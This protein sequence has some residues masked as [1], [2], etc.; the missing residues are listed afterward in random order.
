MCKKRLSGLLSFVFWHFLSTA[1]R[2]ALDTW[3]G[4]S[5]G[6]C[7]RGRA[8]KEREPGPTLPF[9]V[10]PRTRY[11]L[12]PSSGLGQPAPLQGW[13]VHSLFTQCV[14]HYHSSCVPEHVGQHCSGSQAFE[15]EA[16]AS[17]DDREL[18]KGCRCMSQPSGVREGGY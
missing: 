4:T 12:F 2:E 18:N 5:C 11:F 14:N 7:P 6:P 3:G 16:P 9:A 8:G 13:S 17:S 1:T 10:G 15:A